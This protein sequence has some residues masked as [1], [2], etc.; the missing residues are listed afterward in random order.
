M[1][2]YDSDVIAEWKNQLFIAGLR[3]SHVVRLMLEDNR[4]IGEERLL[5]DMGERYR[6]LSVGMDGAL[7]AV[8]DSGKMYRL[9]LKQ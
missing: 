5:Q 4:V 8:T 2:F 6:D 3:G 9:G 7:Y 1:V